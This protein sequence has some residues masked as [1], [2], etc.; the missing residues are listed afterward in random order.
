MSDPGLRHVL[1]LENEVMK[2][3]RERSRKTIYRTDPE[4]W[5]W[6]VLGYR[7]HAK[8]RE[9]VADFVSQRRV[10]V[11]SAN[12]TGKSRGIGELITWGVSTHEPGE[13]LTICSAPTLRQIE[14]TTFAYLAA[15]YSRA[16][17]RG[18]A[19]PGY[20]TDSSH[21]NYREDRTSKAKTLVIGQRPS[22]RDIVGSFQGIRAIG[23]EGAKTWVF[24]D[25]GGALHDDLFVAAEAVTTG[26]GD[27]KICVIG[28]PDR[29]GTYFQRTFE[30]R[31]VSQDWSNHTISAFDLPTFT[32]E[33]VYEDDAMQEAMLKS[34]M[35]DPAWVEQKARAWGEDSARYQ[36]KVLGLFPD[37]ADWCFFSQRV[38]NQAEETDLDP[39][40]RE[41]EEGQQIVLGVDLADGGEDDSKIYINDGGRIRHHSTWNEGEQSANRTH[42]AALATDANI[43]VMDRIGVGAGPF[44]QVAARADRHYTV[45]GAKASEASP[46]PSTWANSRAYWYDRF[47]EGM[48]NGE[49]DLEYDTEEGQALREQLLSIVYEFNGK[50]AIQ[51]EPKKEMRKRGVHS[52]DDLDAA[53]FSYALQA[54]RL[55]EDPEAAL[56]PGDQVSMDPWDAEI[57]GD[58]LAGM[59]I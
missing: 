34:G 41:D 42:E 38:I 14:E 51:I 15:N 32:G 49:I 16:K 40:G 31:K 1:S 6:D 13:L 46:D 23:V 28:N 4:A 52:P 53:I 9:F 33:R 3:I 19:L 39:D 55:A 56:R 29:T 7:W 27:N 2:E 43:V 20:L 12:G 47:R 57:D 8:Q 17:A 21:W 35:I 24:L 37:V 44:R 54:K 18:F 26:A 11:K 45:I 36:S 5:L 59:P 48:Q 22:D 25:E 58:R 10:A 30:D 50:G